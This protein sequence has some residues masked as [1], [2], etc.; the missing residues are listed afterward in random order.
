MSSKT[1]LFR[2]NWLPQLRHPKIAPVMGPF[3]SH[4]I[5]GKALIR[6]QA[7]TLLK[8]K[9]ISAFK[10]SDFRYGAKPV[11]TSHGADVRRD[12]FLLTCRLD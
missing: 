3:F 6:V 11:V 2:A 7:R 10:R 4:F 9:L 1:R 12:W 5:E 8:P